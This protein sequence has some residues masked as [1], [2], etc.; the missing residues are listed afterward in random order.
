MAAASCPSPFTQS[1][2]GQAGEAPCTLCHWQRIQLP[3][4][5]LADGSTH[6]VHSSPRVPTARKL[7]LWLRSP[8]QHGGL[9]H[10]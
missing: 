3:Q 8:V 2:C 9:Q 1:Q 10:T 4:T 6:T 7:F 5:N